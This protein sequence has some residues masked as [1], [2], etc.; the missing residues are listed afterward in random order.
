MGHKV[1]PYGLRLGVIYTWKSN[2][3]GGRDYADSL[4]EDVWIR[5]H[6]RSRL[7]RA[8]ISS[9]AIE[10]KRHQEQIQRMAARIK[11]RAV[12]SKTMPFGNKTGITDQ[13]RALLGAW[14]DQGAKIDQ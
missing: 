3:F 12:I 2:W 6:I 4:H 5:K 14:I 1:N 9:I 7:S 13:E 8:G 11:E 10:R